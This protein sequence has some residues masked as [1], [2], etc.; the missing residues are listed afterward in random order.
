MSDLLAPISKS[1]TRTQS[2]Y[3]NGS[4]R[5]TLDRKVGAGGEGVSQSPL[6]DKAFSTFL[7]QNPPFELPR[8]LAFRFQSFHE[9]HRGSSKYRPFNF[10]RRWTAG[11]VGVC[12]PKAKGHTFESCRARQCL[13]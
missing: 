2:T 1:T 6:K 3:T 13:F 9:I 5:G 8:K 4:V 7:D 12:S 11:L 10:R